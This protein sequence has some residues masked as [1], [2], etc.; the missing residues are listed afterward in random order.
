MSGDE[1]KSIKAGG[2]NLKGAYVSTE[3]GELWLQ[4]AHVSPYQ[5]MNL[6]RGHDPE[7]PRKLLLHRHQIDTIFGKL[8][9][10]GLTLI[11]EKVYSSAGLVKVQITLAKG[12]KKADKREKLK[13][14]DLDRDS[15]RLLRQG[16]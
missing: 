8:H 7:R 3:N 5:R 15:A 9:E 1:A 10:K 12:L 11:P 6:A 16:H 13:R 2:M 14:R 4:N